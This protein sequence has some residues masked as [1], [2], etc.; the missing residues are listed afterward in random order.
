MAE[1]KYI[2]YTLLTGCLVGYSVVK[3]AKTTISTAASAGAAPASTTTATTDASTTKVLT[4]VEENQ[5]SLLCTYVWL[6]TPCT[7]VAQPL[8]P[9]KVVSETAGHPI[10]TLPCARVC[11]HTTLFNAAPPLLF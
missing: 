7:L 1:E 2:Y 9:S 4:N 3:R 6:C 5:R 8:C 10:P 11:A